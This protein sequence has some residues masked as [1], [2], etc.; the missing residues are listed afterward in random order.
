MEQTLAAPATRDEVENAVRRLPYLSG[1]EK[2]TERLDK[3]IECWVAR[4]RQV[5]SAFQHQQL[6]IG[7]SCGK[8][9]RLHQRVYCIIAALNDQSRTCDFVQHLN[10]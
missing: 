7:N 10:N 1:I 4:N 2:T 3:H 6:R 9:P 5:V 8:F